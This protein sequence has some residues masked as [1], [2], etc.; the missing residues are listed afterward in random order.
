HIHFVGHVMIDNLFHQV[1][2]LSRMDVSALPTDA[3]K[4]KLGR[5][6]VVTLHRPSNVDHR[7]TL[8][9][10]V[11]AL[12][13]VS[14]RLPLIFAIHPR[15]RANLEKFGI[16]LQ[17]NFHVTQPLPYMEFLNLWKDAALVLT[18]SGGM[19]EE[20]TALGVPCITLRENTERPVTVVQGTNVIV[21]TDAEKIRAV[22]AR[23]L[24]AHQT[25]NPAR[26]D[27]W[28]GQAASRIVEVIA[29][30]TITRPSSAQKE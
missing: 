30:E 16:T 25:G 17:G 23:I 3:L 26:P 7:E 27:L 21:G 8:V 19:Q 15:T 6:G 5:Y 29:R 20:T 11:G 1:E 12:Q 2:Q 13:G 4:R 22:A 9:R 14:E 18:D 10:I 28:D 24:D